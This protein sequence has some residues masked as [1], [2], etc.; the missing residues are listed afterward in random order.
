MSATNIP[1]N[2]VDTYISL[3]R[4]EKEKISP[5]TIENHWNIRAQ[6]PGVQSVMSARHSL[7]E[8][9]LATVEL[10]KVT[11]NFLSDQISGTILE[12]G[13]GIGRMTKV[14]AQYAKHIVG[15]ELSPI[16]LERAR[17]NLE[18]I[19]NVSLHQGRVTEFIVKEKSFDLVF[20]S[21]VLLHILNPKEL[22]ATIRQLQKASST[23]F[24]VEHTY[25]GEDFPISKYSILRTPQEYEELFKPY[26]LIKS[27]EHSC[28][29]DRFTL[30]LFREK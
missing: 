14:L 24:I 22:E 13:V 21:I 3:G 28:V 19:N 6:R 2:E 10:Q 17:K 9:E 11:L 12:L 15:I 26:K 25:E 8:N 16:M 18:N 4:E 29:G 7:E 27:L 1:K 30:M 23:I 20:D 5:E